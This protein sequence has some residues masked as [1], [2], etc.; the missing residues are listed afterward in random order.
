MAIKKIPVD[1]AVG[2]VIPHDLTE[3]VAG[4]KK[5][6]AF[7]KGHIIQEQDIP[8]L[9][10]IGKN[11]IFVIEINEDELHE[12]DAAKLMAKAIA[13]EGIV[14]DNEPVE[15]KINF[16]AA[17]DGL[18][19]VDVEALFNF[20][21]LG[22]VIL[23]TRHTHTVV[24]KGEALAGCRAIPLVAKKDIVN[25]A[26]DIAKSCEGILKIASWKIRKASI[27]IT[28]Q[29][30]Y[31]GRIKDAFG[32]V[33]TKK[34]KGFGVEV[35]SIS[36]VPDD[37]DRISSA[38]KEAV[39]KGAELIITTGGM[40]VD[41]DDVT[42]IGIKNAGAKDIVYGSPVLPGSMF[43]I[44]YINDNIPIIGLPACGMY[45]KTTV[46]DLVLPRVLVGERFNRDKI[47]ALGHGGFCLN[48][49]KCTFPICPFG[50]GV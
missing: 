31:E 43:L 34:L 39:D 24:K 22:E 6:P 27:V 1:E 19:L 11:H 47:A 7:K 10:A 18:L 45:F 37:Q 36:I 5:G 29:E 38:I 26:V 50:K 17:C 16:Y 41:P 28:G 44:A 20:N 14:Y 35:L 33:L 49:K 46:L 23:S 21:K 15:G 13:G 2:M 9:K 8:K 25:K 4:G 30:V 3:I 12:N 40:S 32:P 48:C 42:R